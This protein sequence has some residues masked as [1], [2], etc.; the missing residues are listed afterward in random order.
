MDFAFQGKNPPTKLAAVA[1]ASN[2]AITN[3]QDP[4]L[5]D[6]GTSNHLTANLNNLSLQ[7][8]YKG[9]EQVIMG[10]GQ[11]LPINHI[12]NG[13]LSTKYH[14]FILKNVLHVP[15]IAMNFLSVH[16]FCLDNNYSCHFD[17]HEL[18]IQ[19][20]PMG[21]LLYKGLS[22]NGVYPIYLKN[23]IKSPSVNTFVNPT[24]SS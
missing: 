22:E 21:R 17:A 4:W 13:T 16:K 19:D 10:N 8:Q 12:G 7:S 18:K 9:P 1:S 20:I 6:L 11:S 5:A 2:A 3:N 15:R 24:T 14:N 23:F